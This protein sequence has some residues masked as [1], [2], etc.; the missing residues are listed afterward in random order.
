MSGYILVGLMLFT[1][2]IAGAY[3]H[4][5]MRQGTALLRMLIYW[6]APLGIIVGLGMRIQ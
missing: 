3:S 6:L 1:S 4:W 2:H 5:T